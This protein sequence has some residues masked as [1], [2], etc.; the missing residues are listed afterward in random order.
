[1]SS[2]NNLQANNPALTTPAIYNSSSS[3]HSTRN[4]RHDISSSRND[5]S[6]APSK[7]DQGWR[8]IIRN[9][10]PSWFSVTMGTGIVSIILI[11]IPYQ[12][13]PS[14]SQP[15]T[16]SSWLYYLSLIFFLLNV[17]F[18]F[19]ASI[20]S[21]LRYTLYPEIWTVMV[22]DPVNSLFLATIPM[23]FA[24]LIEG[25]IFLLCPYWGDWAKYV[26]WGAWML[27][28]VVAFSITAFLSFTLL[29]SERTGTSLARI[30]AA[31]LLPIA[32][33][34][35]AAGTGAEVAEI[36]P[37]AQSQLGTALCCYVMWGA[38]MPLALTVIVVYY[39]RLVVHKLPAREI[40]VSSFLPLGPLGFGGYG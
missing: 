23:G 2:A 32:A 19:L 28:A 14:S 24:T 29:S 21:I 4:A 6:S 1:M 5:A 9:F 20:A 26:A 22:Q 31:Q 16:S 38:G 12:T 7:E 8:R 33:T 17:V 15:Q 30:T 34:L 11:T 10:S 40:I 35:V 13:H 37:G 36:L 3:S 25:W 27:D 18:F 39:Q